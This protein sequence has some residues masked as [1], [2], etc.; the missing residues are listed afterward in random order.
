MLVI[1]N[2][3][4][5]T[6]D[7]HLPQAAVFIENGRFNQ[8]S[9]AESS[10]LPSAAQVI[11][12]A[13]L[14]AVPGF[15]DLQINGALGSDFTADPKAIWEISTLLPR[16]GLSAYLPTI[17]TSPLA[18]IAAAQRVLLEERPSNFSGAEP[19]GLHIEGPFINPHKKGAHNPAYIRNPDE[20][21]IAD[22]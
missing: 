5:Y 16:Y 15:I 18:N 22:P 13:G 4:V 2:A 17:I 11:E 3:A 1:K 6:P 9:S 21:L 20:S 10:R 14:L 7:K 19:L 12:A 8:I